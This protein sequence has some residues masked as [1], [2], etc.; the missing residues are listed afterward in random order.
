[1]T[2][3]TVGC[4]VVRMARK[5][6]PYVHGSATSKAAATSQVLKAEADEARVFAYLQG[7]EGGGATDD[8]VEVAL[9]MLHQTASARRRGLV[10][11]D[12]V[13]DSGRTRETRTGC[14]ATI[15]ITASVAKAM[16]AAA[17]AKDR[18]PIVPLPA[19]SSTCAHGEPRGKCVLCRTRR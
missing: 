16:A 7:C 4:T 19:P 6:L 5:R 1:L 8:E 17:A 11:K 9:H 3:L 18:T 2:C 13:V 12:F 14:H 10:L 15:W